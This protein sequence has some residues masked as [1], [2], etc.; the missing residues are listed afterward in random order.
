M[1]TAEIRYLCRERSSVAYGT[2]VVCGVLRSLCRGSPRSMRASGGALRAE[3]RGE[4]KSLYAPPFRKWSLIPRGFHW[5]SYIYSWE[6]MITKLWVCFLIF[7][8][9]ITQSWGVSRVAEQLLSTSDSRLIF[10]VPQTRHSWKRRP[11]ILDEA[12]SPS[13]IEGGPGESEGWASTRAASGARRSPTA[14]DEAR[15]SS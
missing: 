13:R 8:G 11:A 7:G 12:S 15:N 6:Q 3:V 10:D 1:P 14:N 2:D 4:S 5:S 9:Y